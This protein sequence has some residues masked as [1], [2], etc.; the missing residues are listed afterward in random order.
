MPNSVLSVTTFVLQTLNA[1]GWQR[2]REHRRNPRLISPQERY[3]AMRDQLHPVWNGKQ[4][5]IDSAING[6]DGRNAM[7]DI[8]TIMDNLK[9]MGFDHTRDMNCEHVQ[10]HVDALRQQGLSWRIEEQFEL[11]TRIRILEPREQQGVEGPATSVRQFYDRFFIFWREATRR[12]HEELT[13]TF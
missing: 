8:M 13:F 10:K 2:I 1:Y 9:S 11:L 6:K 12:L 4:P 5:A 3:V 7:R